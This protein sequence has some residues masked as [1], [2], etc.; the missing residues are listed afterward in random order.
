MAGEVGVPKAEEGHRMLEAKSVNG[1]G[2]AATPFRMAALVS[3][4]AIA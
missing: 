4:S 1:M 3:V 2:T